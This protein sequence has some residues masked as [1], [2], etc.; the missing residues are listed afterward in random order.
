M[1]DGT[2]LRDLATDRSL[3]ARLRVATPYLLA[4]L[5]FG[6]GAYALYHLLRP[7]DIHAVADQIRSTPWQVIALALGATF[8]GYLC[9]AAYDWSALRHI[10]KRLPLPVCICSSR[11]TAARCRVSSRC[12]SG[13]RTGASANCAT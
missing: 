9:L 12:V 2:R 4:L 5:L 1:T 7:V 3:V 11:I 6:L 13:C 8:A 10:G